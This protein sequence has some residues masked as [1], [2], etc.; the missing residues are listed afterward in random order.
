MASRINN[1]WVHVAITTVCDSVLVGPNVPDGNGVL[2]EI[3]VSAD[4]MLLHCTLA[5]RARVGRDLTGNAGALTLESGVR[6]RLP[7]SLL[8][9]DHRWSVVDPAVRSLIDKVQ[10]RFF[11]VAFANT[12]ARVDNIVGSPQ[13]W[14]VTVVSEGGLVGIVVGV[15]QQLSLEGDLD[16]AEN[17]TPGEGVRAFDTANG[18]DNILGGATA[19]SDGFNAGLLAH[20]LGED[21][22]GACTVAIVDHHD[23]LCLEGLGSDVAAVLVA[24]NINTSTVLCYERVGQVPVRRSM[25]AVDPKYHVCFELTT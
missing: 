21:S 14:E 25:L 6:D 9:N 4:T 15:M 16:G 13:Q 24:R 22:A 19:E 2:L 8:I 12:I 11:L 20:E 3:N 18:L 17:V 7:H 5:V 23:V 10:R 1:L